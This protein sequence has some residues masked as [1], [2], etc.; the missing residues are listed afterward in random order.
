MRVQADLK[1]IG[2][3]A[4]Q[5]GVATHVLRH[6]EDVG[7]LAPARDPAGRRRYDA[8]DATRVG[9]ILRAKQA[10]LSLD[11][12]RDLFAAPSGADRR[13]RLAAHQADLRARIAELQARHDLL[14]CAVE[15]PAEDIAT[16][17]DFHRALAALT[18]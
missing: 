14:N 2:E 6:W 12:I 13:A 10:G 11:A 7:L 18:R 4:A 3:L 17:P 5:Y 16:C 15:C 8:G 1:S 9:A